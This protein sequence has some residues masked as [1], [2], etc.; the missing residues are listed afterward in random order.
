MRTA[1]IIT[2]GHELYGAQKHVLDLSKAFK[3]DGHE[4]LVIVGSTGA[5]T[6]ACEASGIEYRHIPSLQ[7]AIRIGRDLK[8]C[9]E[10]KSVLKEFKPDVVGSHSSK[11]GFISRWVCFRMGI[12]NTFT[13]HGWSFE[14]GV[15]FARRTIYRILEKMAGKV[16][17]HIITVSNLGKQLAQKHRI[18]PVEKLSTIYYGT[19]DTSNQY[20]KQKQPIFTMS[21]VAGFREQKDHTTLIHALNKIQDREWQLFLLGDGPLLDSIQELVRK[22]K[23]E[24]RVHFEGMV[25]NVPNYLAKTDLL[26]LI[27][28]WEGLPIST[29]EG[30][31]FG[32]P[33]VGSNVS[34]VSEQIINQFNGLT[35]ERGNVDEV[36]QAIASLIDSPTKML[37]FSANSRTLYEENFTLNAMFQK[38]KSLY[39]SLIKRNKK[40][41]QG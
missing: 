17:C 2:L 8:A 41:V 34:G 4:V 35:V 6:E 19:A 22:Y 14:D 10:L 11:A 23:M 15:P 33:V 9:A 26:V 32:L 39:K 25:N 18:V 3:L 5:L 40:S 36:A 7:R 31:A 13:A 27:T 20:K 37:E 30:L 28:N 1:Q 12:A 16:S 38:T 21:M 24:D 29:L